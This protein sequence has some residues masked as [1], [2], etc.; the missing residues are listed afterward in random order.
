MAVMQ[1]YYAEKVITESGKIN[2]DPLLSLSLALN[3]YI[4][5]KI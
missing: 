5:I 1:D 3:L 4:Y 2:R